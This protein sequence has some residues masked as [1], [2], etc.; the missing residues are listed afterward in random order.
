MKHEMEHVMI[1]LETLGVNDNAPVF[2][3]GATFFNPNTGEFGPDFYETIK[4]KS[5]VAAGAIPDMETVIWWMEQEDDA[6]R[7]LIDAS[8]PIDEVL[9]RFSHF[10]KMYG[11]NIQV[12]GNG[13]TFDLTI[14]K[15]AY[16]H[17]GR[18]HPWKFWA[19]RDVRTVVEMGRAS[20]IDPK[21]TTY[22]DGIK[23]NAL[24]DA[25]FQATYVS[26]IWKSLTG[27]AQ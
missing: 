1:D 22:L 5:S 7:A 16:R 8:L 27:V 17:V 4:L 6:R 18:E 26:I 19:E 25:R 24:H 13:A 14:L 2:A 9:R 15:N 10:C 11:K 21:V 23:H 12:W 20:G 3:I